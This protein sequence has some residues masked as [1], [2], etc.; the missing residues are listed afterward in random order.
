MK[1]IDISWMLEEGMAVY[2]N[3]PPYKVSRYKP[4]TSGMSEIHMGNHTGTHVD[5][6]K[7]AV[8]DGKTVEKISLGAVVGKCRVVDMTH[9][10]NGISVDDLKKVKIKKGERI[11]VKTKNS[12]RTTR[13]LFT[14]FIYLSSD[15]AK[16]LAK[17]QIKLFGT[18]YLAVKK[19]GSKDNTAHRALLEKNILIFEGLNFKNV[20]PGAYMFIGLPLKTK[21]LDGAPARAVLIKGKV[22]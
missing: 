22:Q 5:A 9:V 13:K 20:L 1:I 3:N 8:R 21:G 16:F 19:S 17:K 4:K 18:D 7:H 15:G 6:P 2:T 11:L 10:K 14:D 12:N